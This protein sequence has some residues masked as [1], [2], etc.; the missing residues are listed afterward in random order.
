MTQVECVVLVG[1]QAA[2]KS[3]FFARRFAS[4][5]EH[6]SKD[7]FPNARQPASRQ[8]R[9]LDAALSSGRS[10]VIDNTNAAPADRVPIIEAA[11]QHGARAIAYYFEPDT[12]ASV[13]RNR[14]REGKARVPDVAI[15]STAK[16]LVAPS[17]SEGFDEVYAVRADGK[18]DFEVFLICQR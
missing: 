6:I 4:T 12:R 9:L 5:H 13:A 18:G 15:F 10:V 7:R 1:L 14:G 16:R 2:G 8:A 11:H 3:T 17:C